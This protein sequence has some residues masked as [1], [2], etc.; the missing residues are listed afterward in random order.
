M[1]WVKHGVSGRCLVHWTRSAQ[2][3]IDARTVGLPT[4]ASDCTSPD[5]GKFVADGVLSRTYVTDECEF[6]SRD[7]VCRVFI[8][9]VSYRAP[10]NSVIPLKDV[11]RVPGR[12][13]LEMLEGL[14]IL[15][16]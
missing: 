2:R 6:G 14:E 9:Y 10:A 4:V 1:S 7:M 8:M 13:V 12:R 15:E 11:F 5:Q 3:G 16:R